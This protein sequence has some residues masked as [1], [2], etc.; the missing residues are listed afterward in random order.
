M[1]SFSYLLAAVSA[2]TSV[3]AVPT[4]ET[5]ENPA[6][7]K[8]TQ[9]STGNHGGYYYSFWT[10]NPNTVT[11]TNQN[12]GQFSVSWSGNQG[13]FVGGKGWNPGAA[14]TIKY[15][16]TYKPN[17]NSYLAVYGWTRNPL[18]EYYIVENFGTYNPSS[19]ATKKGE[20]NVDGSIY[21]IYTS[22]RT[23]APSIEG[24][25]TFQQ[26]WSVRRNKRTSGSV[27][28]GA[29]FNAWS[30][31]GLKLGSFDYQILAVEGYY[32]SGSATMTV[33]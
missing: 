33:S 24:T 21:D 26:Y 18:I 8:R 9:S 15:S 11:Y 12:A 13:N 5:S 22:T 25:R 2:F 7:S 20:V 6:L 30:N 31:V 19:G 27:N 3:L 23:N 1:V 10:D 29:H 28:T 16:G 17:G 32:S 14:R 4:A